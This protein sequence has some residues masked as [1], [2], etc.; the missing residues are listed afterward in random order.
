MFALVSKTTEYM[1]ATR[2]VK[3]MLT[4]KLYLIHCGRPKIE[5]QYLFFLYCSINTKPTVK[6][7]RHRMTQKY[8]HKKHFLCRNSGQKQEQ[9]L[10]S[11]H[12]FHKDAR[13]WM[14]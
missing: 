6:S 11:N 10:M 1:T 5:N 12:V 13:K 7:V 3:N 2:H 4:R 8:V 9:I 14:H